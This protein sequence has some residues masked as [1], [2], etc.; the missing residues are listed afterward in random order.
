MSCILTD[1][2]LAEFLKLPPALVTR[3]VEETDLPRVEIAGNLRFIDDDVV[4]WLSGQDALLVDEPLDSQEETDEDE[5][6]PLSEADTVILPA[7]EDEVPFVS[8]ISLASLGSGAADPSQNLARQQV[9]DGLAAL[10]DALHPSLVRLSHDRLY[11][12]VTEADRTSQWRYEMGSE[13]IEQVTMTWAEGEGPPGFTDRPHVALAIT[14]DAIEF[15]TR[16]P[17]GPQPSTDLVNRARAAGA[18]IASEKAQGA[19]SVT[20]LYEVARGTPTAA[21]LQAR[22]ERD[23]KTLVPLWLSAVGEVKNA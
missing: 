16:S 13:P 1:E 6:V 5:A 21:V 3:L 7:D 15:T 20:Y 17:E 10:G 4:G 11:P 8:R 14:C 2:E 9:R 23:A 19:W 22:L 12:A 18:M